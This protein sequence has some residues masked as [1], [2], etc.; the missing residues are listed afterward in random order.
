M[1]SVSIVSS[2]IQG[3]GGTYEDADKDEEDGDAGTYVIGR[4][5]EDQVLATWRKGNSVNLG[6]VCLVAMCRL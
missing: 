2:L 5:S 4:S 1:E 3:N 6:T